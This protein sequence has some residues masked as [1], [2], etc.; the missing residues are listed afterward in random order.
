MLPKSLFSAVLA[1]VIVCAASAQVTVGPGAGT[2]ID[3]STTG[4]A[5]LGAGDDTAHGFV[6]TI[7]NNLLPAGNIV[8]SSNGHV[9]AGAN[10]GA[11]YYFNSAILPTSDGTLFGYAA[12]NKVLCPWWDDLY[13]S[14][15]P[16]ATIY[17]QEIAGM[18]IIQWNNIGHFA[19]SSAAG[20]PGI[21]F[22]VQVIGGGCGSIN[23]IYPDATSGGVQAANDN[24]ASATV[25]YVG[26]AGANGQ[27]SFDTPGSIPDGTSL[28]VSA[29]AQ[30]WS[31]PFGP[32]SIQY[33]VCN[34]SPTGNY[35]L[36]VTLNA[37]AF[38]NGWLYGIDITLA[39]IQNE[40]N[41]PIFYGPLD[42]SGSAQVGPFPGLPSGLGLY[43]VTFNIP[44]G[45]V[46]TVHT[47]PAAYVIP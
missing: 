47:S 10:P 33:N 26:G 7:G 32:G 21:T 31:S 8:V 22:Q 19:T 5:L 37:G 6:S 34:G 42:G 3:I 18:L 15:A 20:G 1:C 30:Q 40:L 2:F 45:S 41:A 23:M 39:E 12:T 46:P 38:P 17:W 11:S 27:Y 43:S 24:G 36:L 44:V 29:F 35:Q 25:G 9:I 28:V 13:A 14:G 16:N 4:T